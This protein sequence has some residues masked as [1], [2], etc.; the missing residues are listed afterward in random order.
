[1]RFQ[2]HRDKQ[3][4]LFFDR[5]CGRVREKVG[6]HVAGL[7]HVV[8]GGE[9]HTLGA[10]RRRCE[11]LRGLDHLAVDMRLNVR[12]PKQATLEAAI[13]EV[14]TSRVVRWVDI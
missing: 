2:R 13:E 9:R 8:Y 12:E 4:E 11:F 14:W 10:F 6:P 1:M 5:V 7:D 3:S